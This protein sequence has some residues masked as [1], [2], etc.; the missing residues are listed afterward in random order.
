MRRNVAR[1]NARLGCVPCI[2]LSSAIQWLKSI[3]MPAA[4]LP[5]ADI[6][7]L[8]VEIGRIA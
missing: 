6:H 3:C 1:L 2:A 4:S 8:R 5:I 7:R